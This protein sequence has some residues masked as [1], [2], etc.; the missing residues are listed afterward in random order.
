MS[1][2][3]LPKIQ[4]DTA[5][6]GD[7]NLSDHH[8]ILITAGD[9]LKVASYNVQLMP[10]VI[11]TAENKKT[12]Q[13]INDAVDKLSKYLAS[14]EA[15]VCC[16][17]ELFDN[18]ANDLMIQRMHDK[19]YLAT[20]RV[21]ANQFLSFLNG[22][23]CTFV[24]KKYAQD[25]TSDEYIFQ[26]A[27]DYLVGADAII[28]KGVTHS[29]FTKAGVKHHIFN[30]HLQAFYS[31][32]EHYAEVA[33]AQCV[34]LKKFVEDQ[35]RN[36][37]IGPHDKI[38]L[39]GDFNIPKPDS[40]EIH[41][42]GDKTLL[43]EKMR[44][45]MGPQFIFLDYEPSKERTLSSN[46]SYNRGLMGKSDMDLNFD[47]AIVYNPAPKV[48]SSLLDCEPADI[49]CDIQLAISHYVRKHAT[50]FASW[51]LSTDN[52]KELV[53][54]EQEFS[55]LRKR[56]DEIKKT[57][58]NP[59]DDQEWFLKAVKLLR[60]P[61]Q[62]NLTNRLVEQKASSKATQLDVIT[63]KEP[64][65]F[66]L[67]SCKNAFDKL[68]YDLRVIHDEIR[69]TYVASP[70]GNEEIFIASLKL[71]HELLN[72][73]EKFFEHPTNY[74]FSEFQDRCNKQLGSAKQAFA[75]YHGIWGKIHP[76]FQAII[77][78]IAAITLIP[79][80]LVQMNTQY[81]F[82]KTFFQYPPTTVENFDPVHFLEI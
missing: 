82:K 72:A 48:F 45:M 70:Q 37:M 31:G 59:L 63:L 6:D 50:L 55:R 66:D 14:T 67:D 60:G 29:S 30:T 44:Q 77:G 64:L 47:F 8:P 16:V 11:A 12:P 21:G 24:K 9:I 38:L 23:V 39:C 10:P 73:G 74:T 7:L 34:E 26:N 19:G 28:N 27:I 32:R 5:R 69:S 79:A 51:L 4:I 18:T 22:G 42:S 62:S 57:G 76:I 35:Q 1:Q 13:D 46:N 58:E 15:D 20:T 25:L 17:Q 33:L 81:G 2:T 40:N 41:E 3:P 43:Y 78:V 80:F 56:A 75:Q 53:Q 71:N 49:Y 65:K 68:L 61:G 52:E 54:F 36:G